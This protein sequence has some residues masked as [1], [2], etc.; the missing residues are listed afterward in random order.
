MAITVRFPRNA[1]HVRVVVESEDGGRM[2]AVDLTRKA[3]DT[4]PAE[5]TPEPQLTPHRPQ[6]QPPASSAPA[7]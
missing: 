2:G 5:P 1:T 7:S 3:I 4:A 6:Y